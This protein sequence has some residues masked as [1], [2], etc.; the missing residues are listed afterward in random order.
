[1]FPAQA[2]M[3]RSRRPATPRMTGVPRAGG[4]G[5]SSPRRPPSRSRCSPRRRGWT[6]KSNVERYCSRRVPRAGG[7]GPMLKRVGSDFDQCSPR[8]R[9]WTVAAQAPRPSAAVFPAQA[10]M[11]RFMTSPERIDACV[12]RAGGDGPVTTTTS[13]TTRTCSPRRRGWTDTGRCGHRIGH[14]FPAQAGMDRVDART[15]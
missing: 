8:R 9:G 3:D 1:M 2:G 10:G 14:V 6:G 11:D 15:L 4:D 13:S 7:D 12:P 5:P